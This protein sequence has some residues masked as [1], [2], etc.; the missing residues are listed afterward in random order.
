MVA[1]VGCF[2]GQTK[3]FWCMLKYVAVDTFIVLQIAIIDRRGK[4]DISD[5]A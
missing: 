3:G 1:S 5:K 4:Q 2:G